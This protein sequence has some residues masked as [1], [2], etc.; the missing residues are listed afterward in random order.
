MIALTQI[1]KT[2]I[3]LFIVVLVFKLLSCKDLFNLYA[4][5]AIETVKKATF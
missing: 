3:F 1:T 2:E 4:E 5:K